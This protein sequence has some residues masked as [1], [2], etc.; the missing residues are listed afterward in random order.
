MHVSLAPFQ[1]YYW[2][3]LLDGSMFSPE[4]GARW[5]AFADAV[6]SGACVSLH[7]DGSV[8]PPTPVLNLT[9]SPRMN[10][11]DSNARVSGLLVPA[12]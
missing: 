5:A 9:S 1:Y 4:H 10:P 8:S 11:G 3:E 12:S 6:A 7:N 2:G